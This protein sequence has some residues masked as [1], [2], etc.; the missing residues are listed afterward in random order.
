MIVNK[1]QFIRHPI[2]RWLFTNSRN[3]VTNR[4]KIM[5]SSK[6]NV[7]CAYY[8]IRGAKIFNDGYAIVSSTKETLICSALVGIFIG[9]SVNWA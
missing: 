1:Q 2:G 9:L 3:Y 8:Q 7:L 5:Q 6:G 4:R